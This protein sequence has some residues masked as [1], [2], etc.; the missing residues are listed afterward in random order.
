MILAALESSGNIG[1]VGDVG[2][3]ARTGPIGGLEIDDR[4]WH[5]KE[6]GVIGSNQAIRESMELELVEVPVVCKETMPVLAGFVPELVR[7]DTAYS[8]RLGTP[9]PFESPVGLSILLKTKLPLVEP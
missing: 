9:L 6:V 8:R 3:E 4:L 1:L 2:G 5:I 7:P